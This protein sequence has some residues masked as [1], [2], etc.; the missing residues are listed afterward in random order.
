MKPVVIIVVMLLM[1]SC[2]DAF[3]SVVPSNLVGRTT[4]ASVRWNKTPQRHRYQQSIKRIKQQRR[5]QR[6]MKSKLFGNSRNDGYNDST[7]S[8]RNSSNN[9]NNDS[10]QF[11]SEGQDL[12]SQF[13]KQVQLNEQKQRQGM[14]NTKNS[15]DQ[16]ADDMIER[17]SNND[18]VI[19]KFT[20]RSSFSEVTSATAS[21]TDFS[22]PPVRANPF[23]SSSSLFSSSSSEP[24][25]A[26]LN[27]QYRTEFNAV[28]RF[29]QTIF[30]QAGFIVAALIFVIWVGISGGITDGSDRY[31]ED[32]TDT[33]SFLYNSNDIPE[34]VFEKKLIDTMK[35]NDPTS[36]WL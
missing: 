30:L 2:T 31:M 19:K 24:G 9:D 36:V 11:N 25:S 15:N 17:S 10:N 33:P 7:N 14:M 8:N 22:G 27:E 21:D 35:D 23:S 16:S 28:N 12:A 20:G 32:D 4:F 6:L 1:S 26:A 5:Y 18:N 3:H 34:V 29:E 13:Y